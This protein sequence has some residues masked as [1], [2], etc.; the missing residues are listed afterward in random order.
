MGS[1][2][3]CRPVRSAF[4]TVAED[5]DGFVGRLFCIAWNM[6][7]DY[8]YN[9]SSHDVQGNSRFLFRIPIGLLGS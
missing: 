5:G 8:V 3:T 6:V 4:L 2:Q 1:L 7:I 9:A